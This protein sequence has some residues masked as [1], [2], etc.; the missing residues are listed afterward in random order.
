MDE[1]R[2][3]TGISKLDE[4]LSG[5]IPRNNTVLISG[6]P[7]TGKSIFGWQFLI[8][9]AINDDEAG[10]FVTLEERP[11]DIRSNLKNFGWDIASLEAKKQIAIIDA[12]SPKIGIPSRERYVE[13]KPFDIDSLMYKIHNVV[14][15][16][17][18]R[19]VV[20][21]SIPALGFRME[22]GNIRDSIY[23]L[24][25]LLLEIGCTTLM[26]SEQVDPTGYSRFKIAEYVAHGLI[27]L[28]LLE[29][30]NELKRSGVVVKMRG[31]RHSMRIF[32]MEITEKGLTIL[33]SELY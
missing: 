24:N 4:I 25:A 11:E 16:I 22:E 23:K 12:A 9:G 29:K 20:L 33:G 28:N 31:T 27:S 14:N 6:G 7:G 3:K 32:P 1:S 13:L 10:V 8:N 21:D 26:V 2:A 17:K 30:G 15:E 5:G 19:R 18:A